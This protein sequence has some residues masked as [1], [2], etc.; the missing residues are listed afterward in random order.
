MAGWSEWSAASEPM[1]TQAGNPDPPPPPRLFFHTDSIIHVKWGAANPCGSP[2]DGYELQKR[3]IRASD[4]VGGGEAAAWHLAPW[5]TIGVN[6][7]EC[8]YVLSTLA[9]GLS[10]SAFNEG[11]RNTSWVSVYPCTH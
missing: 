5:E 7:V 10:C 9:W 11:C 2:V 6:F 3:E 8:E 4:A 1:V